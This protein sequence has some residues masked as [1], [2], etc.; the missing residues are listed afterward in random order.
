MI[1]RRFI[2]TFLACF[3]SAFV[4]ATAPGAKNDPVHA[5]ILPANFAGWQLQ[6]N[7]QTSTDPATADPTNT[8]ILKEYGFTE[9]ASGAFTRDDGR[10]L[11]IRAARFA[12]ASGAYGAFTY[13]KQ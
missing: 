3:L 9:F 1:L 7:L 5:T 6:G 13:Y 11:T 4:F 2:P 10:K 12:D 8:A